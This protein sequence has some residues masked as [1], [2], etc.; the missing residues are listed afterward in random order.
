MLTALYGIAHMHLFGYPTLPNLL[1]IR[2]LSASKQLRLSTHRK[3]NYV[4]STL[5]REGMCTTTSISWRL[6]RSVQLCGVLET[7]LHRRNN[8]S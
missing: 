1:S 5:K 4:W 3:P 6:Q 2:G 7:V 8:T